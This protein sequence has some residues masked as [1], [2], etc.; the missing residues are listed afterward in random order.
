M[1]KRNDAVRKRNLAQRE[2]EAELSQ[3][4]ADSLAPK[5]D[6]TT[7]ALRVTAVSGIN[8]ACLRTAGEVAAATQGV[9][10]TL[11]LHDSMQAQEARLHD[12]LE[13]TQTIAKQPME[14]RGKCSAACGSHVFDSR[15]LMCSEGHKFCGTCAGNAIIT[16]LAPQRR[17]VPS[18]LGV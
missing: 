9:L 16:S 18:S 14:L 4:A 11:Q 12:V 8:A 13:Q 5:V 10:D 1:V 2:E 17:T 6:E 15:M 3:F 7:L